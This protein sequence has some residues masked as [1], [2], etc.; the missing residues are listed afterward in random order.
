MQPNAENNGNPPLQLLILQTTVIKAIQA[1]LIDRFDLSN[2]ACKE[3][4]L[5]LL[6]GN[7][8]AF[9]AVKKCFWLRR[10]AHFRRR[11]DFS[12]KESNG[13]YICSLLYG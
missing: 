6:G 3:A 2:K 9:P 7:S 10:G 13:K 5:G 11:N 4:G 12:R 1:Q 8:G